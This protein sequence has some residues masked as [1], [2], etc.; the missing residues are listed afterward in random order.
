MAS[1]HPVA[2]P[3]QGQKEPQV[4]MGQFAPGPAFPAAMPM[5]PQVITQQPVGYVAT[6]GPQT[7]DWSSSLLGDCCK[8]PTACL[9]SHFCFFCYTC[10][11]L[12]RMGE[13]CWV[14]WMFFPFALVPMRVK[15]RTQ[16]GIQGDLCNDVCMTFWCESC[17]LAQLSR[18]ID[19]VNGQPAMD[20]Q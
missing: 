19:Y 12:P 7:R 5:Q 13:N 10:Q 14:G 4:V 15:M 2:D 20:R 11:V 6:A 3:T 8:D 1:V 18:E 9:C 17:V 16:Y